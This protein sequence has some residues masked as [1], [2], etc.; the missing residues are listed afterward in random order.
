MK[1]E[2][3]NLSRTRGF[4]WERLHM[5]PRFE[6]DDPVTLFPLME[7]MICKNNVVF[8]F[9]EHLA[10]IDDRDAGGHDIKKDYI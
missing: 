10:D 1:L 8:I 5:G 2:W 9:Y 3:H 6:T 7:N 4:H